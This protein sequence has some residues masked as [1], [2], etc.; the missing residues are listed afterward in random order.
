MRL[1]FLIASSILAKCWW[2]NKSYKLY[3]GQEHFIKIYLEGAEFSSVLLQSLFLGF[4]TKIGLAT[5]R[6]HHFSAALN[7]KVKVL[8][9]HKHDNR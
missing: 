9:P 7:D 3:D 6:F 2:V 4:P 1:V 5:K 8:S